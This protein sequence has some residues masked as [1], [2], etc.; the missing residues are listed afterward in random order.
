MIRWRASIAPILCLLAIVRAAW[1]SDDAY[2]TLRTIDNFWNG[3]GLRWN[4]IERVQ[5]Y[6]HPLWMLLLAAGYGIT[7][8][9]QWTTLVVSLLCVAGSLV[10]LIRRLPVAAA[11]LA[12]VCLTSSRAFVEFSTSGLETPLSFLLLVAFWLLALQ[13]A[14]GAGLL[15]GL[16]ILNRLD[17]ALLVGPAWLALA[18]RQTTPRAT[19]RVLAW[20]LIPVMAWFAFAWIYYGAFLPNTALAKLDTGIGAMTLLQ[21][22]LWYLQES[23]RSDPITP[24]VITIAIAWGLATRRWSVASGLVLFLAYV[25][26]V[27]GDFMS[28]RFL[29]PAF[30]TGVLILAREAA[31]PI[32]QRPAWLAAACAATIGISVVGGVHSPWRVWEAAPVAGEPIG[33]FHGI[34]DEQRIYAPYTGVVAALVGRRPADHPW[35]RAGKA[36][37]NF[38]HVMVYEAVGLLGYHAGPAV[39]IVDPMGLTDPLLARLPALPDWRIGHF[40]RAI[41]AGYVEGLEECMRRVFPHAAVAPPVASC[42]AWPQDTNR[43][44]DPAIAREYDR[45]RLITQGALFSGS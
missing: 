5:S 36:T 20:G 17:L 7:R 10:L 4:V 23:W 34:V 2:I 45:V 28:G 24:A 44:V 13:R 41:P 40:R 42:L 9:A 11:V 18:R 25:V 43:I 8:E 39:H 15:A 29:A 31:R 14:P 32:E 38:P 19:M 30:V 37:G 3:Y 22:G 33:N 6:T 35:A 16:C 12:V 1:L 27:G 21:Q 26:R